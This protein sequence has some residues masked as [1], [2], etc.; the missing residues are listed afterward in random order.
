MLYGVLFTVT[1]VNLDRLRSELQFRGDA[2]VALDDVLHDPAVR[3]GLRCGPLTFPNHKLVPDARWVADLPFAKVRARADPRVGSHPGRGVHV[4]VS[5]RFAIFKHAWTDDNDPATIQVPPAG[6][7]RVVH[8][9]YSRPMS[10]AETTA[11]PRPATAA[12]RAPRRRR[13]G[14]AAF[15]LALAALMAGALVLRLVGFRSGLPYVYNADEDA[16]F[17]PRAIGMFGHA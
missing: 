15:A 14:T 11:A 2:H 4:Y 7:V 10:P 9:A 5:S 3:A 6:A 1:R 17:V 12:A 8:N 13:R 16:H